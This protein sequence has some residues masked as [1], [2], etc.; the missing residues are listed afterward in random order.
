MI[1]VFAILFPSCIVLQIA[2]GTGES[3]S[4]TTLQK[5]YDFYSTLIPV[6]LLIQV[7]IHKS[8]PSIR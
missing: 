4:H 1:A 8:N 2:K 7:R 6:V 3:E 5:A